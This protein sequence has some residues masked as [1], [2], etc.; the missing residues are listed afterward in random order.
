MTDA[1]RALPDWFFGNVAAN[2]DG[3]ALRAPDGARSYAELD[4]AAGRL[5]HRLTAELGRRPARVAIFGE[6]LTATFEAYLAV[7]YA[8]ATVVPLNPEF[9]DDRN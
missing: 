3:C 6:R 9:P 7:L 8:G 2:R 4:A 5:A 1:W